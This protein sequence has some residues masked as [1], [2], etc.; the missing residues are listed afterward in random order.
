MNALVNSIEGV[1]FA[2]LLLCPFGL[3]ALLGGMGTQ[4]A[5]RQGHRVRSAL[6]FLPIQALMVLLLF[7]PSL[8]E[9][10]AQPFPWVPVYCLCLIVAASYLGTCVF[11]AVAVVRYGQK[12][13]H[14]GAAVAGAGLILLMALLG[15]YSAICRSARYDASQ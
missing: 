8:A 4:E 7:V 1:L 15:C 3:L 9:S 11:S 12:K 5:V 6:C 13:T 10:S 2:T 14:I